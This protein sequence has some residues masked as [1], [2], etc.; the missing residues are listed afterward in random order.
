[1]GLWNRV[2]KVTCNNL[3]CFLVVLF[4][5]IGCIFVYKQKSTHLFKISSTIGASWFWSTSAKLFPSNSNRQTVTAIQHRPAIWVLHKQNQHRAF[6]TLQYDTVT[7]VITDSWIITWLSE[8]LE[9]IVVA[10]RSLNCW[11]MTIMG[12]LGK[13]NVSLFSKCSLLPEWTRSEPQSHFNV[14]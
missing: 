11:L 5:W 6:S 7:T 12:N 3:S 4:L 2:T 10:K 13:F 8:Y 14:A 1:M 9:M